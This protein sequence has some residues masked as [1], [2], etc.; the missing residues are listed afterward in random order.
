VVQV[1]VQGAVQA[2]VQVEEEVV[3]ELEMLEVLEVL[4]VLVAALQEPLVV[5]MLSV[6]GRLV[7]VTVALDS[8]LVHQ[9]L[10]R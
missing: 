3:G 4:E 9:L 10:E 5:L 2:V 8:A 1:V 7:E 6:E